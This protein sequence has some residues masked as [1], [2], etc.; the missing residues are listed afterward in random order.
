MKNKNLKLEPHFP[1]SSGTSINLFSTCFL[2]TQD[3][4]SGNQDESQPCD[5]PKPPHATNIETLL[6][7]P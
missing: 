6:W 5:P 2:L 1:I 3:S 4:N 7:S